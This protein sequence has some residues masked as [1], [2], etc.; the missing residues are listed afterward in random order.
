MTTSKEAWIYI[1]VM[2]S[3]FCINFK[4]KC[5]DVTHKQT[6]QKIKV[7]TIGQESWNV[8]RNGFV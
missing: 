5:L 4:G 3:L 7:L 8:R 2:L 6:I 1:L